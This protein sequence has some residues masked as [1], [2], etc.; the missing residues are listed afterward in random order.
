MAHAPE[1]QGHTTASAEGRHHAYY[2][3]TLSPSLSS[4]LSPNS[5][6]TFPSLSLSVISTNL[7]EGEGASGGFLCSSHSYRRG[8]FF[9]CPTPSPCQREAPQSPHACCKRVSKRSRA[10]TLRQR[11]GPVL[12]PALSS[13][14]FRVGTQPTR[15]KLAIA[16]SVQKPFRL[17]LD[18]LFSDF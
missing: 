17:I 10:G 18:H 14:P 11:E 1:L 12:N 4:S 2:H 9:S 13:N 7:V 16:S 6:S 5:L 8:G 3:L 15:N